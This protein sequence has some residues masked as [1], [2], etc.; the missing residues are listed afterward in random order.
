M[1]PTDLIEMHACNLVERTDVS[2]YPST[3]FEKISDEIL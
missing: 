2:L 1:E 3:K